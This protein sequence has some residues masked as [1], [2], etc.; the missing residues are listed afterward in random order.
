MKTFTQD[1][2][3]QLRSQHSTKWQRLADAGLKPQRIAEVINHHLDEE[4]KR[5]LERPPLKE[6]EDK[7]K[8]AQAVI[9]THLQRASLAKA[10]FEKLLAELRAEFPDLTIQVLEVAAD[11]GELEQLKA[12]SALQAA[13][14][15]ELQADVDARA[16]VILQQAQEIAL[17]DERI[18][19]LEAEK[20]APDA[21][22]AK[23]KAK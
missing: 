6:A 20:S 5:Q 19:Q 7:L 3:N 8:A 13:R 18:A 22:P 21:K 15:E 9:A 12:A 2:L 1:E 14:I 11:A 16:Q 10:E 17:R 4:A 23:S